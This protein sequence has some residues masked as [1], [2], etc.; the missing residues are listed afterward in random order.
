M[1]RLPRALTYET[2]FCGSMRAIVL[3]TL[4]ESDQIPA[5]PLPV[6]AVEPVCGLLRLGGVSPRTVA[7]GVDVAAGELAVE[8]DE[9]LLAE[10]AV[11][12]GL[13]PPPP[14]PQAARTSDATRDDTNVDLFFISIVLFGRARS[15]KSAI[16]C[17]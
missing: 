16:S 3:S 7:V 5:T 14:P 6:A 8:G 1:V 4:D 15:L 11:V 10:A 12:D 2:L 17:P 13:E 9:A